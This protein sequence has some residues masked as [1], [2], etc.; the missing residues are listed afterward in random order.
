M[1][2]VF[3][4]VSYVRCWESGRA[5]QHSSGLTSAAVPEVGKKAGGFTV[6]RGKYWRFI[7]GIHSRTSALGRRCSV[8]SPQFHSILAQ[9]HGNT[10]GRPPNALLCV[11]AHHFSSLHFCLCG[12]TCYKVI[13]G[14][15]TR[16]KSQKFTLYFFCL[17]QLLEIYPLW[18]HWDL[19]QVSHDTCSKVLAPLLVEGPENNSSLFI[20]MI[21]LC[22]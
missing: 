17:L 16:Q 15:S 14:F 13:S 2:N 20:T 11:S 8:N 22:L 3:W 10:S 18:W 1:F 12:A 6:R 7:S 5:R 19:S 9:V 4:Q 21:W